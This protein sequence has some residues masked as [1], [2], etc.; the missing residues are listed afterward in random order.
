MFV[1]WQ[2]VKN[3]KETLVWKF[4]MI[5]SDF[6]QLLGVIYGH[7]LE[8]LEICADAPGEDKYSCIYF[9]YL[10]FCIP[11]LEWRGW[12]GTGWNIFMLNHFTVLP[13]ICVIVIHLWCYY[14]CIMCKPIKS[15][16]MC[17]CRRNSQSSHLND[18]G[19][20]AILGVHQKVRSSCAF[21]FCFSLLSFL[22]SFFF[23]LHL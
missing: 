1:I 14:L 19:L 7:I 16:H 17:L 8:H 4:V 18:L 3:P 5:I 13:C 21:V 9:V 23:S 15:M 12:C 2:H 6:L 20:L 11:L 10:N 22:R